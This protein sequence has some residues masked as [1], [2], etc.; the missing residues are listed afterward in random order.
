MI[1][2]I[3]LNSNDGESTAAFWSAI[4]NVEPED[5]GDGRWRIEP[6]AGPAVVVRTVTVWQAI[7][8]YA[9]VTVV[10]VPG[11]AN[12]LRALGFEVALD[13]SQAVDVNGTDATVFLV[14]KG[15]DGHSD[16]PWEEPSDEEKARIERLLS[17]SAAKTGDEIDPER[18]YRPRLALIVLYVPPLLL[19]E[20]ARFYGALLDVDPVQEKHGGG[21]EHWS[22]S[23]RL[24]GLVIEVYPAGDRPATRTR[25]EFR[26]TTVR[27]SVARLTEIGVEVEQVGRHSWKA[28]DPAGNVVMLGG[29]DSYERLTAPSGITW[30]EGHPP[31]RE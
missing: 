15:W 17:E 18:F 23:S 9:D 13:G 10:P 4:F 29:S 3:H 30:T 12:R 28:A 27:E 1:T 5:L 6:V 22:I 31:T 21:P 26:G 7:S 14:N 2:A 25:L 24:T 16:V 19:D 11:A 20:A 8:R